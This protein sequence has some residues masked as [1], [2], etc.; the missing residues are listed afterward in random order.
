MIV[1]ELFAGSCS[2]SNVA[3][4]YEWETFT[5]DWKQ[6][7]AIDYV[8][9]ILDIDYSKLPDAD[10]IWASPPCTTFSVASMGYHW[11]GG[12]GAYIPKTDEAKTGLEIL[13]KTLEVINTMDPEYWFIE[14]PR[15][16]MR[17]M[18]VMKEIEH[19]L[20]TPW[21]CQYGDS[22]A[23]PTDIWSNLRWEAKTCKNGNP[24]CSHE[25]A[26]RGARTGTQGLKNA[27]D[28]SK[29]PKELCEELIL[30][31]IGSGTKTPSQTKL[32]DH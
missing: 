21:Y 22:R 7:G 9:D 28:R 19:C 30:G 20:Q 23:K 24:Y 14:N 16:V 29:V 10:I 17:K 27:Y 25:R 8:A 18:M 4:K 13:K 31:I 12:A 3:R 32:S 5:T 26:P 11:T 1:I 2:F 6:Y 15:G